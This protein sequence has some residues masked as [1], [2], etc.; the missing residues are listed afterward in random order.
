MTA[1]TLI[2]EAIGIIA[3]EKH[4]PGTS[5]AINI[6]RQARDLL[7]VTGA[8][9]VVDD[10]IA[11]P[12]KKV[13]KKAVKKVIAGANTGAKRGRKPNIKPA[14]VPA[15]QAT[16]DVATADVAPDAQATPKR[17]GRKPNNVVI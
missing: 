7:A 17:R 13:A 1:S 10:I 2:K 16:T 15:T 6:L 4:S 8:Q 11:K 5:D 14:V 3:A 12:A 9:V